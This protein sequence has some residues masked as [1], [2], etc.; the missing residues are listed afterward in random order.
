MAFGLLGLASGAFLDRLD[1]DPIRLDGP[2]R[3]VFQ[4][5]TDLPDKTAITFDVLAGGDDK[6]IKSDVKP[7]T[8][9]ASVR[10]E[11]IRLRATL[12]TKDPSVTPVL[13]SWAITGSTND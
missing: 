7:G 2:Q 13:E 3:G 11:S 6:V 12:A 8:S 9:L 10:A 1:T 5:K 4:V